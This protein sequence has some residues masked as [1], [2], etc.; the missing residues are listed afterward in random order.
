[1]EEEIVIKFKK[2]V[3]DDE[4]ME[5]LRRWVYDNSDDNLNLDTYYDKSTD[6]FIGLD[7]LEAVNFKIAK[8]LSFLSFI[9][10]K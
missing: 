4:Y 8:Y 2:Y 5:Y 1:M 10:C 6:T 9:S 7:T 3:E